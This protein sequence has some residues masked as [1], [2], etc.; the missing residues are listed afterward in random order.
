MPCVLTVHPVAAQA[1]D[2]ALSGIEEAFGERPIERMNLDDLRISPDLVG[3]KGSPTRL[4]SMTR[5]RRKR[6]CEFIAGSVEEQAD[7]LLK[8][9]DVMKSRLHKDAVYSTSSSL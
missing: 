8:I 6:K 7:E 9:Y 1:R 3:E 4:I 2:S 5:I